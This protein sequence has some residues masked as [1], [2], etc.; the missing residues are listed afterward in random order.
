MSDSRGPD[1]LAERLVRL[2][3]S[4]YEARTY[5]GL[6]RHGEL[7]GYALANQTGVPQ[8]KI[9]ETLRRL[10]DRGA[11]AQTTQHPARYVAVSSET[12]LGALEQEVVLQPVA[13]VRRSD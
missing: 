12:L 8:P 1:A 5:L 7:T 10:L 2:G 6:L 9:Y 13:V 3:F 4:Q 11:V